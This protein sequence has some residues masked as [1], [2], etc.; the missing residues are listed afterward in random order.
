MSSGMSSS[1]PTRRSP[2]VESFW[3]GLLQDGTTAGNLDGPKSIFSLQISQTP[4]HAPV[5]GNAGSMAAERRG[6]TP[7]YARSIPKSL[8]M[9]RFP[10]GQAT[11]DTSERKSLPA[12]PS[13]EGKPRIRQRFT[14]RRG[15]I[16][17]PLF[18]PFHPWFLFDLPFLSTA[19]RRTSSKLWP[20]S[21]ARD[22]HVTAH[23][24]AP[25]CGRRIGSDTIGQ[26]PPA[27]ACHERS[28]TFRLQR[29]LT[30]D[31]LLLPVHTFDS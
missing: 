7:S 4:C 6:R 1:H 11:Q 9:A 17:G 5:E 22:G 16:R 15:S 10:P 3:I 24:E 8:S 29:G 26:I 30:A 31:G 13:E 28:E 2:Q 12:G 18:R 14:D 27:I 19:D 21:N 25:G 23:E 20:R